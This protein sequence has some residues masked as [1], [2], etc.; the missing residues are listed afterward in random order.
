MKQLF[1][2]NLGLKLLSLVLALVIWASVVARSP[3]VRR[4]QVPIEFQEGPNQI[5]TSYEPSLLDV[6]LSGDAT[7][8]ER[9]SAQGIYAEVSV[10]QLQPGQ[11]RLVTVVPGEL[12]QI[13]R[14]VN[15]IEILNPQ[16]RVDLDR[17]ETKLVDVQLDRVGTPPKGYGISNVSVEPSE[18]EADGPARLL[19]TVETIR[20]E[21][22]SLQGRRSSFTNLVKLVPPDR[23]VRLEPSSVRV[24]IGIVEA[25]VT[26]TMEVSVVSSDG[27]WSFEPA[28]VEVSFQATPSLLARAREQVVARA[29][30]EDLPA[31]GG[32][33]PVVLSWGDLRNEEIGRIRNVEISP[34]RVTALP[35]GVDATP[36]GSEE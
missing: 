31:T 36:P 25:R 22:V 26:R 24:R 8:L 28:R 11:H 2:R 6:R 3:G 20:T 29:Y 14:G 30:T 12:R 23:H 7:M 16:I 32:E 27:D 15:N 4:F 10:K 34:G 19:K 33:V 18:V 17:R 35:A 9:I 1:R 13:P 21:I 5:V